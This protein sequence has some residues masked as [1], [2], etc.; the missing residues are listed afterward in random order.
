[1]VAPSKEAY[2]GFARMTADQEGKAIGK[3]ATTNRRA[4]PACPMLF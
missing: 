3:K 4:E 1:M 2:R